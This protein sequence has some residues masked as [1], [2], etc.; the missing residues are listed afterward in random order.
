MSTS[1]RYPRNIDEKDKN[2]QALFADQA[3]LFMGGKDCTVLALKGRNLIG[4]SYEPESGTRLFV[5]GLCGSVS[6]KRAFENDFLSLRSQMKSRF[7]SRDLNVHMTYDFI[8]AYLSAKF[9]DRK[10][11]KPV[12]M[13]FIVGQVKE[14][15][16][17]FYPV[18]YNGI[19]R[20]T[21]KASD[22]F[23]IGCAGEKARQELEDKVA[24][25]GIDK[26]S[27]D[28]IIEAIEPLLENYPGN[29]SAMGFDFKTE[30]PK[31]KPKNKAK[32]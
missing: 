32:K 16:L 24:K 6:D 30:K 26:M 27:S 23:V 10:S 21:E 8:N 12:A 29:F 11:D 18:G 31:S 2:I 19:T 3:G 25:L 1:L 20:N 17:I 28:E 15:Q 14:H 13:E 7:S 5:W 4:I 22:I 9:Y